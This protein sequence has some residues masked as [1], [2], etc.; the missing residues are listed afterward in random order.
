MLPFTVTCGAPQDN[1]QEGFGMPQRIITDARGQ[2]WDV[3]HQEGRADV[4][5]RHQSGME[6]RAYL[7]GSLDALSTEQ[8]LDA[9]DR[10]SRDEGRDEVGHSGLD[11]SFD[12]DGYET[13][14]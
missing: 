10:A 1:G 14:P 2:R 9:L 5:F 6:L 13:K 11:V 8:L 7:E 12:A 4:V 3:I